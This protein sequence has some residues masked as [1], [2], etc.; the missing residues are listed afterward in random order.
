MNGEMSFD[1]VAAVNQISIQYELAG[2]IEFSY[3]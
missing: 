2:Q 3:S 1:F